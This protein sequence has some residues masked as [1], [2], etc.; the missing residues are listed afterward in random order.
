MTGATSVLTVSEMFGPTFQGEGPFTGRTAV[1]LRLGRCNLDCS[2]CD[3]PYTWDWKGKNGTVYDPAVELTRMTVRDVTDQLRSLMRN[4]FTRVV[5]SGGE[6]MLQ[7]TGLEALVAELRSLMV[8]NIDIETNGT[9]PPI[10][11]SV[12]GLDAINY[13]ISP[14]LPSSGVSWKHKWY[15]TLDLYRERAS[16]GYAAL[17]FVIADEVDMEWADIII[18]ACEWDAS[19]VWLMPEGRTAA[20]LDRNAQVVAAQALERGHNYSDR[21]H[22]RL[23]GDERGR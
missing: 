11:S 23:W 22:V 15:D 4:P 12:L 5:I 19:R 2:W 18:D 17:K 13:V 1:F 3:T 8:P 6:P 7:S 10:E 14:K 16:M 20:E 21:L 9:R